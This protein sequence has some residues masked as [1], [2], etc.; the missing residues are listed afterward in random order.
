M[1]SNQELLSPN[2]AVQAAADSTERDA[3]HEDEED[4]HELHEEDDHEMHDDELCETDDE[5]GELD[6][7]G[8]CRKRKR[9]IL[10]SKTQTYELERRFRQQRYL[11]APEREHLASLINLTPT[12][13]KI[14][15]QNHRYKTKKLFREKG[16]SSGLDSPYL[17]SGLAL[18]RLPLVVRDRLASGLPQCN[19]NPTTLGTSLHPDTNPLGLHSSLSLQSTPVGFP[20]LL[21]GLFGSPVLR[22][23]S[24]LSVSGL[25]GV[26]G[27][28]PALAASLL[29]PHHHLLPHA[30]LP[31][32]S[33]SSLSCPSPSSLTQNLFTPVCSMASSSSRLLTSTLQSCVSLPNSLNITAPSAGETCNEALTPI[34]CSSPSSPSDRPISPTKW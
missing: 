10:F 24:P 11:S 8:R 6:T 19:P 13:V 31:P 1:I 16:F 27:L 20:G 23:C 26:T 18:R 21:S 22:H 34:K 4:D 12:Q 3:E 15:F 7:E 9:R 29:F 30:T 2:G 25:P 14:W 17:S 32:S 33:L 28:H 5:A